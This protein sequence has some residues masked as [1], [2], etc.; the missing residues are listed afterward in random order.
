MADPEGAPGTSLFRTRRARRRV[1]AAVVVAGA[2]FAGYALS[3]L[4]Y[5]APLVPRAE[6]VGLVIGLPVDEAK[7][8]LE[9]HGFRVRV[10]ST[11][12]PDP[13]L[14]A[15][16]ITWQEPPPFVE[17]P[18]G[19]PVELTVSQGPAPVTV[20]DVLQFELGQARRVVGAAG[21]LVGSV[22]S[23][24]TSSE[25]GVVVAIRPPVGTPLRPGSAVELMVSRGP[26]RIEVPELV[27][28]PETEAR[29][30]LEALGLRVGLVRMVPRG[31]TRTGI[32][33]E[34]RPRPGTVSAR[35]GRVDLTVTDVRI[36]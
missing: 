30:R 18:E 27:G 15:G 21:L 12:E 19:T 25:P 1:L 24:S 34:Q 29:A 17:L 13:T 2:A 31:T 33:V 10:L 23:V 22:D 26:P 3:L 32:V 5:P 7:R 20:P 16:Y 28:L 6:R 8:E 14:P 11:T 4:V 9:R 36:R 35:G